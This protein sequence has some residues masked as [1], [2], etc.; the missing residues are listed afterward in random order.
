MLYELLS[1]RL[2]YP[3]E[4]G[5]LATVIRHINEDPTPLADVAPGSAPPRVR[6][7]HAGTRA[8]SRR[9]IRDRPRPSGLPSAKP[10]VPR[11]AAAGWS[12][13]GV[14]LREPG[15]ILSQRAE[16]AGASSAPAVN[17]R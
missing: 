14:A 12:V 5:S 1:G 4:G 13:S 6:R 9:P 8:R 10:P 15:P 11:G 16:R 7:R 3:E 2:P 17:R